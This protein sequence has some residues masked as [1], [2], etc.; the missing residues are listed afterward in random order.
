VKQEIETGK[1]VE[2][3]LAV[4]KENKT[5]CIIIILVIKVMGIILVRGDY[6]MDLVSEIPQW[7]TVGDRTKV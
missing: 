3:D 6:I 2:K 4:E 1:E 5:I 7:K